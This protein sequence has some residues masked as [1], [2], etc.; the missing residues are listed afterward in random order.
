MSKILDIPVSTNWEVPKILNLCIITSWTVNLYWITRVL[1]WSVIMLFICW[2]K[3]Q[4]ANPCFSSWQ[5]VWPVSWIDLNACHDKSIHNFFDLFCMFT[6][7]GDGS[8][9]GGEGSNFQLVTKLSFKALSSKNNIVT[10]QCYHAT[11]LHD[12]KVVAVNLWEKSMSDLLLFSLYPIG[13]ATSNLWSFAPS[14]LVACGCISVV[15]VAMLSLWWSG[16]QGC[17]RGCMSARVCVEKCV[18]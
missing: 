13:W 4:A 2:P 12:L 5:W 16:C 6:C 11:I 1:H 15:G 14:S 7:I 18:Q 3:L 9:S 10:T 8:Q 17:Q